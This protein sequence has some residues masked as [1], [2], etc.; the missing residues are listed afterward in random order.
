MVNGNNVS[1]D[2]L[3]GLLTECTVV[4]G[5]DMVLTGTVGN[6]K[7][8]MTSAA[9][10]GTVF[11]VTGTVS[12]DGQTISGNWSGKGGCADGQS[13]ALQLQYVP[14]ITGKWTGVLGALP[15]LSGLPTASPGGLGGAAVTFQFEQSATPVQFSFPLSG[16]ISIS[17]STCGF[18]SG[19]LLQISPS[20][21][22]VPSSITGPTWDIEATMDD[23]SQLIATGV[24]SAISGQWIA[25]L[26][27]QGGACNGAEAQATLTGP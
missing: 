22:L 13:G 20:V 19:T 26:E 3:P 16:T 27:V 25:V 14:S 9:W 15:V 2:F 10:G 11:T 4:S 18:S 24:K 17:G 5:V 7:I 21:P 6:S 12:S 1:A 23:G 8:S